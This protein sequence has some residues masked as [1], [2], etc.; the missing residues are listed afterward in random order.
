MF[1]RFLAL[2]MVALMV[3]LPSAFSQGYGF[4]SRQPWGAYAN[5][6]VPQKSPLSPSGWKLVPAFPNLTFEDPIFFTAIP[7][8]QDLVVGGRQ[9][10]IW[11]FSNQPT[12][13]GKTV[14]LDISNRTQG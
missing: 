12:T 7:R 8:S 11:R 13:T 1:C 3:L 9:G 10:K 14:F 4:D 6:R 2:S 5:N